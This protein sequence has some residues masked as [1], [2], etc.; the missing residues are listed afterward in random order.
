MWP[1]RR[2]LLSTST[3][4]CIGP[5]ARVIRR[6]SR[7][8]PSSRTTRVG[9]SS[10]TGWPLSRSTTLTNATRSRA[11][12]SS[13]TGHSSAVKVPT[14]RSR[15]RGEPCGPGTAESRSI[16]PRAGAGPGRDWGAAG[17]HWSMAM[18][19]R[20]TLAP[21]A[22]SAPSAWRS[23]SPSCSVLPAAT[24]STAGWAPR[25]GSRSSAFC[26]DRRRHPQRGAHDAR[27]EQLRAPAGRRPARS[28]RT[29]RDRPDPRRHAGAPRARRALARCGDADRSVHSCSGPA[30]RS[31]AWRVGGGLLL[32]AGLRRHPGRSRRA[33]W[34]LRTSAGELRPRRIVRA[35]GGRCFVKF[36]T[37]HAYWPSA[38]TL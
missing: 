31:A 28:H 24:G 3:A 38:H 1:A 25:R 9:E 18:T 16:V 7:R 29:P 32:G 11:C 4:M 36:F 23:S 30:N 21:L 2:V 13:S 12:A 37:R 27:R 6:T 10:V 34:R 5:V 26:R 19:R 8:T 22:S 14:A 33:D 17:L 35:A 20:P 15:R